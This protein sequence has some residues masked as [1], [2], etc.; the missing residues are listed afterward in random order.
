MWRQGNRLRWWSLAI[1]GSLLGMASKEVMLTAPV[2]L[3]LFD[4]A[5]LYPSWRSIWESRPRRWLYAGVTITAAIPI[6][7]MA[8]GARGGTVGFDLGMNWYRYAY[9]QAI[10]V[11]RYVGLMF[12]PASLS[13]DYGQRPLHGPLGLPGLAAIA[14]AVAATVMAWRSERWRGLGFLGAFFFIVLSP[15]SS[16]VPISTEVGAERRMYLA[17][18]AVLLVVALGCMSVFRSS[19][20]RKFLAAVVPLVMIALFA[21]TFVRSREYTTPEAL[22]SGALSVVPTNARAYNSLAGFSIRST[23]PRLDVADSLF[24]EAIAVDSAFTPAWTG[25]G[26][27]AVKLARLDEAEAFL[28]HALALA[29]GDSEATTQLGRVFVANGKPDRALP[30]LLAVAKRFPSSEAL[31]DVG[32][33]YLTLGAVDSAVATLGRAARLD[34]MNATAL[35]YLSGALVEVGRGGEAVPYATRAVQLQ[36]NAGLP[37]GLLALACAQSGDSNCATRVAQA[38]VQGSPNNPMVLVFAGRA[39]QTIGRNAD[40][41]QFFAEAV[42]LDPRDTQAMTRLGTVLASLGR[43]GEAVAWFRRA[44]T[45]APG[46]AP[47]QQGLARLSGR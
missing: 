2:V 18:A 20:G 5:F 24:R 25:R 16:I 3:V 6:F 42:R 9:T 12:W 7:L 26:A 14:V 13:Y 29:P 1:A 28:G 4:R 37:L 38:A 39:L 11:P 23:P 27:I 34:S 8:H 45:I 17:S 36:P 46:Y 30:L 22:W 44:L 47:A 41:A 35:N 21:R 33:A 40:A 10:L 19:R 32:T 43:N 31:T 15:S